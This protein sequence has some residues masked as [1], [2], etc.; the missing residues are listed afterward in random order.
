[1]NNWGG[2]YAI[3]AVLYSSNGKK[4]QFF[5]KNLFYPYSSKEMTL[6]SLTKTDK[7]MHMIKPE[8]KS[9]VVILI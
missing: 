4:T 2:F 9:S 8:L 3:L 1:M 6:C 5:S 7:F